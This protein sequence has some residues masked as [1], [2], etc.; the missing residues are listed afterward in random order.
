MKKKSI[1]HEEDIFNMDEISEFTVFEQILNLKEIYD[2]LWMTCLEFIQFERKW[3]HEPIL[4]M[5][6][7]DFEQKVHAMW[8]T[9]YKLT[10]I[11]KTPDLKGPLRVT[12]KLKTKS[13]RLKSYMR[14]IQVLTSPGLKPRHW[15]SMHELLGF[16]IKPD[17]QTCLHDFID[18]AP[19]I[20]KCIEKLIAIV[21]LANK[22][23]KLEVSFGKMQ[24]DWENVEFA[25]CPYKERDVYVLSSFSEITSLIDDHILKTLSIKSSPL[26]TEFRNDVNNW[27]NNLVIYVYRQ[28]LYYKIKLYN[29]NFLFKR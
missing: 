26:F 10:K 11:F 19:L 15:N 16:D 12:L 29:Y 21:N 7:D 6:S 22:E 25:F 20:E 13:E 8:S 2:K 1:K 5:S 3:M 18:K 9:A 24:S 27:Y 4:G 23:F 17:E 28:L 14:L